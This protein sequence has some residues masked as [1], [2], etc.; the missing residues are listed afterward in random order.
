MSDKRMTAAQYECAKKKILKEFPEEFHSPLAQIGWEM[1]AYGYEDV[2]DFMSWVAGT[3]KF[4]LE[5]YTKRI[6][7][8]HKV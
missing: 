6:T 1:H 3:L 5:Q 4:P 7:N 2:L 8:E